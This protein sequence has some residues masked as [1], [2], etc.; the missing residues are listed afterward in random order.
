MKDYQLAW[1]NLWRN[2]RR[3]MITAASVFF[4]VFFALVMRSFQLGT[5]DHMF[6]NVIESYTGYLQIQDSAFADEPV[7]DNC[8]VLSDQQVSALEADKNIDKVI[9]RIESFALAASG[10]RT[11]G[12]IVMGID[13]VLENEVSG[14]KDRLVKYRFTPEIVKEMSED[15]VPDKI[16]KLL[17]LFENESY[18][19]VG[20]L[21]A[22]LDLKESDTAVILPLI[23]KKASFPNGYFG[24]T[25]PGVLIGD[26][27]SVYLHLNVG[28]TLV[29][30]GQGYHASSAAAKYVVDG[31]V[32][33]PTP[34]I[35]NKIVYLTVNSARLFYDT[36]GMVTSAVLD[37]KDNSEEAIAETKT[38][39]SS[40]LSSPLK[41]LVWQEMNEILVNQMEADSKS[42]LIMIGILY[43]VIAFGVFGTVLMMMSERK[44]EFGMLI[45][46]GMQKRRLAKV[47]SI[48]LILMGL[49]GLITG[50]IATIPFAFYFNTHPIRFTG[51]MARMYEDYGFEPVMPFMLPDTYYLWQ[52]LV[53]LIMLVIA[54]FFCIRKIYRINVINAL[55]A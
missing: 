28:D 13:P 19:S 7:I 41:V 18:S 12:V 42:G 27:L 43:L 36:P 44:R 22:D 32:K 10:N 55:R 38:R 48:E 54:V 45:S 46:I 34:D 4:A 3:T 26:K 11:Q 15:S 35:D 53:V 37:I 49:L 6:K 16:K 5:Y 23:R 51:Q 17:P 1:K 40:T 24:E 52:T 9:P 21:M 20:R 8:F 29:M 50:V 25:S 30:V 14:I 47:V 39:I 33:L 2:R 31:I